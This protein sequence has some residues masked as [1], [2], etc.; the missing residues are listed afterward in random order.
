MEREREDLALAERHIVE[1]ETR[2][3]A[4]EARIA[5]LGPTREGFAEATGLLA[6]MR[7]SLAAMN[8]HRDLILD[9][10]ARKGKDPV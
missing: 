2:I 3:T 4:Q 10:L 9:A 8:R 1:T 6:G 5:R 7:Q